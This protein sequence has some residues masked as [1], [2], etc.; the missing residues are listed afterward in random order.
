MNKEFANP[1]IT[2]KQIDELNSDRRN[3]PL[4]K[5]VIHG[6]LWIFGLKILTKGLGLI[7]TVVLARLLSPSDF[8]LFGIA[9]LSISIIENFSQTGI[10]AALVRKKNDIASYLN[11]AWTITALRGIVLFMIL[12]AVAPVIAKFFNSQQA[13]AVIRVIAVS[14]LFSGFKN[15]GLVY[16]QREL[17]FRKQ[18]TYELSGVLADVVIAIVLAFVLQSVWA[19][20][21]AGLSIIPSKT[22]FR[23]RTAC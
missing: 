9:L 22:N 10:Q 11:T 21:W 7:R 12:F 20:V 17:E 23:Q 3:Y 5:K 13:T 2:D 15:I 19:L 6:G 4:A 8:G 18:F 16:F 14:T 1:I